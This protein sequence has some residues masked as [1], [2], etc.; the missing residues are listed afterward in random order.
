MSGFNIKVEVDIGELRKLDRMIGGAKDTLK[1]I[2]RGMIFVGRR[3]RVAWETKR[4]PVHSF[5]ILNWV[6]ANRGIDPVAPYPEE[7]R[8]QEAWL[9]DQAQDAV[10]RAINTRRDQSDRVRV[11]LGRGGGGVALMMKESALDRLVSGRTGL[12]NAPSR[13]A[14]KAR[15][16]RQG[17]FKRGVGRFDQVA[18]VIEGRA[19]PQP[20]PF[21]IDTGRLARSI[22]T[23]WN[24]GYRRQAP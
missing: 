13:R 9:A 24:L 11:A 15:L 8:Q 10:D 17:G 23:R 16:S 20:P 22:R 12:V 3:K 5:L 4:N 7:K 21:L 1:D 19:V 14:K 2:G 6:R 18:K